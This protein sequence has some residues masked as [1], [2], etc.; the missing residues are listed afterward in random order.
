MAHPIIL[1]VDNDSGSNQLYSVINAITKKVP[2][3]AAPYIR[4][5]GNLYLVATP[6][7]AGNGPSTIEDFFDDQTKGLTLNGKTFNPNKEM[8]S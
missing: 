5:V 2:D 6:L 4:I 1:L 8:G 7:K 3:H